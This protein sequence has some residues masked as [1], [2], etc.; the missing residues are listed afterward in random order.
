MEAFSFLF[1]VTNGFMQFYCNTLEGLLPL[2][3][4]NWVEF[5]PFYDLS[6]DFQPSSGFFW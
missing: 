6:L 4:Y 2:I 3:L 1:S 5:T